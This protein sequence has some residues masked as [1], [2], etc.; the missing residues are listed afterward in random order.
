MFSSYVK[1]QKTVGSA[2]ETKIYGII[3][4][5]TGVNEA[6]AI[7]GFSKKIMN[8][9]DA[10]GLFL[11]DRLVNLWYDNSVICWRFSYADESIMLR[12]LIAMLLRKGALFTLNNSTVSAF[13]HAK[14]FYSD[15]FEHP[16][17]F[18]ISASS[19]ETTS[20]TYCS[21]LLVRAIRDRNHDFL[22]YA[23]HYFSTDEL[24][25]LLIS[26]FNSTFYTNNEIIVLDS[27]K[28]ISTV[29]DDL[30][31]STVSEDVYS[32]LSLLEG[33]PLRPHLAHNQLTLALEDR[34]FFD[35]D[36]LLSP[37][38]IQPC[39]HLMIHGNCSPLEFYIDSVCD[40]SSSI[41]KYDILTLILMVRKGVLF[42]QQAMTK[43][44]GFIIG[45][46]ASE[47]LSLKY[48]LLSV[49]FDRYDAETK[50]V[51]D[52]RLGHESDVLSCLFKL[53]ICS[54]SLFYSVL[55]SSSHYR[56]VVAKPVILSVFD[57]LCNN[58]SHNILRALIMRLNPDDLCLLL[59]HSS[60]IEHLNCF[61]NRAEFH[62]ALA[63]GDHSNLFKRYLCASEFFNSCRLDTGSTPLKQLSVMALLYQF[64]MPLIQN[65]LSKMSAITYRNLIMCCLRNMFLFLL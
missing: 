13:Y 30:C 6:F 20:R 3:N 37:D 10:N 11:L 62:M 35:I 22:N 51:Y 26:F 38:C 25:I 49:L 48:H 56:R 17:M 15:L 14:E 24:K 1:P 47:H 52:Y 34:D 32:N 36:D 27:Y 53:S 2:T 63:I 44:F 33:D 8:N 46:F 59:E 55:D 16:S 64:S 50:G 4:E 12:S 39:L 61:I 54:D 23:E 19:I 57:F 45:P 5:F 21:N 18:Y 42:N 58:R 28:K 31:K 41:E 29:V 9:T 7:S 40:K 65:F 60:V 43:L